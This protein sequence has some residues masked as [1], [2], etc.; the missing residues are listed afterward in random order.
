MNGVIKTLTEKGFGFI[1]REGEAKDLFF[2]S[3]E[4]KGVTFEEL[5]VGDAVTFEVADSEKGPNAINVSR[6]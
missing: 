3:K 1:T 2:H 6:V 4:L 5:K